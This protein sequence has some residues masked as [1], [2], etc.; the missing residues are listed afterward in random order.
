MKELFY[1][2]KYLPLEIAKIVAEQVIAAGADGQVKYAVAVLDRSGT[3]RVLLSDDGAGILA[4]ETARRKAYTAAVMGMDTRAFAEAVIGPAF[5][6]APPRDVD[7]QLLAVPGGVP[8]V[9]DGEVL[10]GIGVGGAV[11]EIDA[12][13][14]QFAVDKFHELLV[15]R[16]SEI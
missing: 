6:A 5:A 1:L 16:K 7:P 2:M 9:V 8:I 3:T 11:G 15:Q 13:Q 14:A 4:I 10:G 12:V